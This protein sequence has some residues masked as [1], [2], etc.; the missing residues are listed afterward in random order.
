MD[1]DRALREDHVEP[2]LLLLQ[3]TADG[4][5]D[6]LQP[7]HFVAEVAAVLVTADQRYFAKASHL[8]R[9]VWL[10]DFDLD[11]TGPGKAPPLAFSPPR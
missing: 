3:A 1:A 10:P 9:I 4:T 11:R 6:L 7:P 2:A 8:G 5:V